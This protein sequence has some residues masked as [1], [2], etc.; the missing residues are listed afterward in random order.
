ME[1]LLERLP[2]KPYSALTRYT[3]TTLF[4]LGALLVMMLMRLTS[5]LQGISCSIQRSSWQR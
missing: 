2:R 3:L 1:R 5:P 4:V